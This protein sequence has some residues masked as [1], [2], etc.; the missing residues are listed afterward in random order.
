MGETQFVWFKGYLEEGESVRLHGDAFA[1]SESR[2]LDLNTL[3]A[4][5]QLTE[6][7]IISQLTSFSKQELVD[8]F[9]SIVK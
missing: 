4:I 5:P 7:K 9:F 3:L 2:F 1:R 6:S 8:G